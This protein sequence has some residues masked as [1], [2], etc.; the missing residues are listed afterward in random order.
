MATAEHPDDPLESAR[1]ADDRVT[2][3]GRVRCALCADDA[4]EDHEWCAAARD[5]V[6]DDCCEG[7]L[8]G[9]PARLLAALHDTAQEVTPLEILA[10][11]AMCPRLARMIPDEE[12]AAGPSDTSILH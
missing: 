1:P 10:S 5:L 8:G 11:C 3:D 2:W 9:D 4:G 6:C 7:V 12:D